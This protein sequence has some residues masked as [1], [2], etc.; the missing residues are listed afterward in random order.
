MN[1]KRYLIY[2]DILG[3]EK[4]AS[5]IGTKKRIEPRKIR[6]DFIQV[7]S[8]KVESLNKS[9]RITGFHYDE[10]DSWILIVNKLDQIFLII[11][12]LL[13]HNSGHDDYRQIPLEIAVGVGNYDMWAVTHGRQVKTED[14]TIAFLK[15][16]IINHYHRWLKEN[17]NSSPK[18]SF[19]LFTET[20]YQDLEPLDKKKC[21]IIKSITRDGVIKIIVADIIRFTEKGKVLQFL[22][23][24]NFADNRWYGRINEIYVP[25]IEYEEIIQILENK[26]LLFLTGTPEYG[27]TYTAIR[28]LWEKYTCGYKPIWFTGTDLYDRKEE[29]EILGRIGTVLK[30][31]NIIYFEDPFGRLTYE[32]DDFLERTMGIIINNIKKVDDIYIVITSREEPFKEFK[33]NLIGDCELDDYEVMLNIKRPSYDNEKREQ[34]LLRWSEE[35][36]CDWIKNDQTYKMVLDSIRTNE[37]ALSTPLS[38]K[39]F[40]ITTASKRPKQNLIQIIHAHSEASAK[41]F[42]KEIINMTDIY[43]LF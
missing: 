41:A 23:Q 7:I 2:L 15:T 19:I 22:E 25:P 16:Y 4:L 10:G 39:S 33:R 8:D 24:I 40:A 27:K 35:N 31:K 26:R 6:R 20:V 30:E 42:A 32:S 38:M 29:R 1:Q 36:D 37:K 3:F 18:E 5:E 12:E 13:N 17:M 14:D 11:S 28:L 21:R 43:W 34:I 9:G